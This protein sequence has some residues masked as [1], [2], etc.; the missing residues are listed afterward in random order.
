L[1]RKYR[2]LLPAAAI[3]WIG[4]I[5]L[6]LLAIRWFNRQ[7]YAVPEYTVFHA[8]RS[9]AHHLLLESSPVLLCLGLILLPI[10][11]SWTASIFSLRGSRRQFFWVALSL[12]LVGFFLAFHRVRDT[13]LMP[14]LQQILDSQGVWP[15]PE[16]LGSGTAT[17]GSVPRIVISIVVIVAWV[18]FLAQIEWAARKTAETSPNRVLYP[19]EH[20]AAQRCFG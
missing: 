8:N 1:L 2:V 15:R 7:P 18:A 3:L 20:S 5:G 16:L 10:L 11:I 17:L 14:W 12:A 4:S 9:A 6:I 19:P 13:A